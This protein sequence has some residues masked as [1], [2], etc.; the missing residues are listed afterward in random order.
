M[1]KKLKIHK[2]ENSSFRD[3]SGIVFYQD[4]RVYRQVNRSYKQNFEALFKSGLYKKLVQEQLLLP[5][6]RVNHPPFKSGTSYM[7]MEADKIPFISYPYEWAFS[8]LKDAALL[9]LAIEKKALDYGMSL[10]DASSYNTQFF[11]GK[12]IFIDL[13]S[14]EKYNKGRPWVAYRQFCQHFLGPL[15]LMSYVDLRLNQLLRIYIDGIPLDLVSK[16]LPKKTVLNFLLFSHIHLHAKN[17]QLFGEGDKKRRAKKI[18]MSFQ[19][20][21]RIIESLESAIKKL[22]LKEKKSEWGDYYSFTNYSRQAFSKKKQLVDSFIKRIRP[23]T[24]WDLGSNTGEFTRIAAD[25]GKYVVSF[26]IDPLAVERNYLLVKENKEKNILPLI[27]DLINPSSSLGW[28]LKERRSIF[29]RGPA[30]GVLAL[31]LLHHLAIANNVPFEK[32]AEFFAGITR[33]LIIEFIPKEDSQVGKMLSQREDIFSSYDQKNFEKVF[34]RL[35]KIV[36]ID[37][38]KGTVRSLYLMEKKDEKN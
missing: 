27:V 13:L 30:D 17:Q 2:R 20:L 33:Y 19:T 37:K 15:S 16:L 9:T 3:P 35:F 28:N 34:S 24:V 12:P 10:K 29:D 11:L 18:F 1:Q 6:K 23:K 25:T 5:H 26:D 36:S 14:F 4:D 38:I 7:V 8:Q 32:I 22:T 31:A 21:L